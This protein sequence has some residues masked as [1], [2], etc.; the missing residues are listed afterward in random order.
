[1]NEDKEYEEYLHKYKYKYGLSRFNCD[2]KQCYW[3]DQCEETLTEQERCDIEMNNFSCS[4]F[5]PLDIDIDYII[6]QNRYEFRKEYFD[7]Y[8]EFI[9]EW[10]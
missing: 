5:D 1:M 4:D 2:C 9:K 3:Q 7:S 8:N 10:N 6:E